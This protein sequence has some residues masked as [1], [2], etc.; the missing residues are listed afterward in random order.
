MYSVGGVLYSVI[1][2]CFDGVSLDC[3]KGLIDIAEEFQLKKLFYACN[4]RNS[5]SELFGNINFLC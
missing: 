1:D 3:K 4:S 2:Y 5:S